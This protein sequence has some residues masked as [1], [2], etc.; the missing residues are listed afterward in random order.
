M[1]CASSPRA[2][3]R[4]RAVLD[5]WLKQRQQLTSNTT[6]KDIEAIK[7]IIQLTTLNGPRWTA[8]VPPASRPRDRNLEDASASAQLLHATSECAM[9]SDRAELMSNVINVVTVGNLLTCAHFISEIPAK[10]SDISQWLNTV[11]ATQYMS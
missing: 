11:L 5:G 2:A 3:P 7:H 6:N 4:V 10:R 9:R 8:A 1:P